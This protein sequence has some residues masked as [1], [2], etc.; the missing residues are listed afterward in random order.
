[1]LY[2]S[3]PFTFTMSC[4]LTTVVPSSPPWSVPACFAPAREIVRSPTFLITYLPSASL[5]LAKHAGENKLS[6]LSQQLLDFRQLNLS[7]RNHRHSLPARLLPLLDTERGLLLLV[8]AV[9]GFLRDLKRPD[10]ILDL[11][12]VPLEIVDATVDVPH[13]GDGNRRL[14]HVVH[15]FGHLLQEGGLKVVL[16]I[17]KRG[18][19]L[20]LHVGDCVGNALGREV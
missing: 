14:E 15:D 2:P 9:D 16:Q 19:V 11:A 12:D 18:S 10:T 13:F 5:R 8:L 6:H 3:I 20:L 17:G 1:M 4:S 7:T